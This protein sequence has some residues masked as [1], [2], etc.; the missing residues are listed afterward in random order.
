MNL[1][2]YLFA[3]AAGAFSTALA[4]SNAT[5]AKDLAQ[6]I[7]SGLIVQVVTIAALLLVGVTYGGMR[8]PDTSAVAKLPW[9]AWIGG[10]G[11]ATVLLSQLFAAQK[12]G[13]APYLAL[14]VTAGIVMSI[15]LDHFG[16]IGFDQVKAQVGRLFGGGLMIAGVVLVAR[17]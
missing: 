11:G 6:P 16:W 12:I 5:L 3:I 17:N 15:A 13:A 9:W 14:T 7:T 8:W 4:G 1:G 10:V 2:L